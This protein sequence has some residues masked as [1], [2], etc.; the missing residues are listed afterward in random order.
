MCAEYD[1]LLDILVQHP[2]IKIDVLFEPDDYETKKGS[3]YNGPNL[4]WGNLVAF[5]EKID[6][7]FFKSLQFVDL[8]RREYVKRI[9]NQ[10]MF[11]VLAQKYP[12]LS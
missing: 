2:N 8:H 4:V 9:Q 3:D 7:E 1:G 12:G 11:V 5:L 6:A 10:P